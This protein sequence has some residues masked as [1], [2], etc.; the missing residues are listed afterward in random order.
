VIHCTCIGNLG[1]DAETKTIPSGKI[2]TNFRMATRGRDKDAAPT[3]LRAAIWGER[4]KKVAAYLTKGSK[5]A[6]SGTLTAREHEGKTYLEIDVSELE[7]LGGKP[8]AKAADD[9]DSIPF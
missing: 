8:E 3:W 1:A 5:V 9:A 4:G 6:V 2:V 7:L